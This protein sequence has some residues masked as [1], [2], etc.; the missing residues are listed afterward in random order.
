LLLL[1]KRHELNPH[2]YADDTQIYGSSSPGNTAELQERAST[3][4]DETGLW[5]RS[6]GLQ[7][8]T[9]KTEVMWCSSGRRQ[10]QIPTAAF[11]VGNDF[12]QP[13]TSVRDLGIYIDSDLSMST[14]VSKTVSSCFGMLRQ[15]KSIRRSVTRPVLTSLV[16]ALVL[17]RLDY[18]C[19]TLA[20]ITDELLSRLQSVQNAAARLIF[21][22]RKFD[23]VTPLLRDLHWL[24]VRE[25]IEFRLAVLVY[26]CLHGMA[27]DYL[28]SELQRVSDIESRQRLRSASTAALVVPAARR[29]T[30]GDRAFPVAAAR[31]W[32]TLPPAVTSAPSLPAFR[33]RLK[34]ELFK[35]SHKPDRH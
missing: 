23:H 25:R 15:L 34:T 4:I 27:P 9:A 24:R 26:R 32:N 8:N 7:L 6:N 2:L 28:A 12:V 19:A 17:T 21:S 29:K 22:A 18:G 30:I 35:R 3:C 1:I 33:Q 20:G 10:H 16:V 13:T 5:M 31:T 14:H 11:R